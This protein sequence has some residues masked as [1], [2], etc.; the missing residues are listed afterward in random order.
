MKNI[1]SRRMLIRIRQGN[2]RDQNVQLRPK[3]LE[4]L[5][6]YWRVDEAQGIPVSSLD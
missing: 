6:K 5:R 4:T 3:L 2:E 1:N